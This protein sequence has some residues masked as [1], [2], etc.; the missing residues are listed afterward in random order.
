M[1]SRRSDGV[2][3]L[4]VIAVVYGIWSLLHYIGSESRLL[5]DSQLYSEMLRSRGSKVA[6]LAY[7]QSIISLVAYM[8]FI[9][10]GIAILK[11]RNWG[12]V[13]LVTISSVQFALSFIFPY[14]AVRMMSDHKAWFL[15]TPIPILYAINIWF[16]SK[17]RI[18][19]EFRG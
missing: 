10:G 8:L 19:E 6:Q 11:V 15:P 4:G 16:L 1:E 7:V 13:L 12:R 9:I 17:K 3:V 18:K 5:T 2:L 14:V